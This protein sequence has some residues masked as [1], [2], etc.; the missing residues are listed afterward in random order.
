MHDVACGEVVEAV[1]GDERVVG[2]W[3]VLVA[4]RADELAE[5]ASELERSARAVSVPERHLALLARRGTHRHAIEGDV[6]DAPGARTQDERL[7]RSRLVDHLLVEF[8]DARAVRHEHPE[9]SP[10]GDRAAVGD[11]QSLCAVSCTHRVGDA[12]P[13]DAR[14]QLGEL[15]ARISATQQI[16]GVA[17]PVVGQLGKARAAP[18]NG[19]ECGAGDV[20]VHR[21]VRDDLLGEHVEGIAQKAGR[22]DLPRHH[23]VGHDGRLQQ[24]VA[25]LGEHLADARL[26][27]LV[28]R[29]TDALH[30]AGDRT[31][32]FDLHHEVDCPHVDAELEAAR[33]DERAQL[34][35]LQL[36]LDDHALLAG[37]RAV[38][39]LDEFVDPRAADSAFEG[40]LVDVGGESLGLASCVAEDDGALVFEHEVQDLRIDARPDARAALGERSRRGTAAQLRRRLA[41]VPHVLD[42]HDDF[43]VEF[44]AHARVDDRHR[45]R[46]PVA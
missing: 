26:A 21:D 28:T 20:R 13:H 43:D 19:G 15:L 23:L 35:A 33:G 1:V 34:P 32:R 38:V 40:E 44:L 46:H 7:T 8:P 45:A 16:Q 11:G 22:L 25:V 39:R 36:V 10:I 37:E 24:V 31:G 14:L 2:V 27:D 18:Q 6:L 41:E 5:C 9:Q 4:D 42:G 12:I 30:T 3:A 29:A 17:E